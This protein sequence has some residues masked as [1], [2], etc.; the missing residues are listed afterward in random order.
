[1]TK[2]LY[3][4]CLRRACFWPW[5]IVNDATVFQFPADFKLGKDAAGLLGHAAC[6]M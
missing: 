5:S 2:P 3:A 1:M 4:P 6:R